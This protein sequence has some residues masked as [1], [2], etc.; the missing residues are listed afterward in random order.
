MLVNSRST[1]KFFDDHL[2]YSSYTSRQEFSV[3]SLVLLRVATYAQ[4]NCSG[5][6]K[7]GVPVPLGHQ[8]STYGPKYPHTQKQAAIHHGFRSLHRPSPSPTFGDLG[9]ACS[10]VSRYAF[11]QFSTVSRYLP[12]LVVGYLLIDVTQGN[13]MQ[14]QCVCMCV[15]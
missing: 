9:R 2:P 5:Q 11:D 3:L 10:T 15:P 8:H 14:P 12:A 4:F 13:M 6:D 7:F 1:N